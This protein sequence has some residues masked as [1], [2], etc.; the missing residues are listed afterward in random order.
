MKKLF[1]MAICCLQLA[2]TIET[3]AAPPLRVLMP[4]R[5]SDGSMVMPSDVDIATWAV[6]EVQ[7]SIARFCVQRYDVFLKVPSIFRSFSHKF[8]EVW[9]FIPI[10]AIG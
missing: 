8:L 5:L 4:M 2:L 1:L 6:E 10:F 7:P 3:F 9:R